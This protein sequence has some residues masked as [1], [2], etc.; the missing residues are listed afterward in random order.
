MYSECA[1]SIDISTFL[2]SGKLKGHL[3]KLKGHLKLKNFLW[4][5]KMTCYGQI[6]AIRGISVC[7]LNCPDNVR[8]MCDCFL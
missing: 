4:V 8:Y 3:K 6:L 5:C 2:E 1:K 7:F